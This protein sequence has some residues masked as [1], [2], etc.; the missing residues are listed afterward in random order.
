MTKEEVSVAEPGLWNWKDQALVLVLSCCGSLASLQARR[1]A[2][3][4]LWALVSAW[5]RDPSFPMGLV[6]CLPSLLSLPE[7]LEGDTPQAGKRWTLHNHSI[8][9][10]TKNL[11]L[12]QSC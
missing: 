11:G 1:G 10:K 8:I 6:F 3:P 9:I 2:A 4:T 5:F 12:V 7:F